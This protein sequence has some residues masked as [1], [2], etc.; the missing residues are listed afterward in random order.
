MHRKFRT[1]LLAAVAGFLLAGVAVAQ[2]ST[3]FDLSWHFLS[4]GGGERQ[5][6]N[7]VVQDS[8]GQWVSGA[9]SSANAQIAPGFLSGAVLASATFT[10]TPTAP[11]SST[12]TPTPTQTPTLPS[13]S[14]PSLTPTI[15]ADAYE[16]DNACTRA[17]AIAVGGVAQTHNFHIPGDTDWVKFNVVAGKTYILETSDVG[18]RSDAV[19]FLYN[20]C[21]A[22]PLS[23]EDNPFASTLRLQFDATRG[24][25]YYVKLQQ[26]DPSVAGS[27]TYYHLSLSVDSEPPAPPHLQRLIAGNRTLGVRW[28]RNLEADVVGYRVWI[29][30]APGAYGRIEDVTPVGPDTTYYAVDELN[31]GTRYYVAVSAVD[32]S[33][34]ESARSTELSEAPNPPPDST[35]PSLTINRPSASSVYT[36]TVGAVT[37]GGIASDA[38][39]NLSRVHV[40]NVT[41]GVDGWDYTLTGSSSPFLVNNIGLS[42]GSNE[43]QVTVFDDAGNSSSVTLSVTQL[44]AA[45]GAVIIIAGHNDTNSLQPNIFNATNRAYRVFRGAGFRDE[46]IYYL[47]PSPQDPNG[48]GTAN[49]VDAITSADNVRQAIQ[50][51]A[52]ARV[53]PGRPL[54]M[55]IMD[56]GEIEFLCADGC[57]TAG[58]VAPADLDAWL[59]DLES[60]SGVDEV[61]II[62]EAC[63]SGS[64]IDRVGS[65]AQSISKPGR[66]IITSTGRD[67]NAYA[68]VQGAYFSDAFFT[69]LSSSGDLRSCFDQAKSAVSAVASNQT[70]WI[71]DNGDGISNVTDGNIAKNRYVAKLF[72][73]LPPRVVDASVARI[74]TTGILTATVERGDDPLEIVW[75]AVYPP[76]FREPTATTLDLGV[77][78]IRLEPVPQNEGLFRADYPNGFIES[79]DYRVVFFAQ[80]RSGDNAPPKVVSVRTGGKLY[81]PLI[82]RGWGTGSLI[83][84][85]EP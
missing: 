54:Y 21:D 49:E 36:T 65:I 7:F 56:H 17:S 22:P 40:Q 71:D 10:P 26:H 23:S 62:Y 48:D 24:G 43:V 45:P 44:S 16:D 47:S 5:S 75:A 8:L 76:S 58:R 4:A 52:R 11:L 74:G 19:A 46:D 53:G 28:Q 20:R 38:G 34:N 59:R 69:C 83:N 18:P 30:T 72:G 85:T 66:V 3:S 33:G 37:I 61:N 12:S 42:V 50:T 79:G 9:S 67:N 68:S 31:N 13:T 2:V 60:K 70:P 57:Q 39:G 35:I 84:L 1:R 14:T 15:L 64:F 78:L 82:A 73:A 41:L 81:L 27:D 80:D 29:G 77:P 55:Y 32:F 6:A 63:H 51:W 25:T